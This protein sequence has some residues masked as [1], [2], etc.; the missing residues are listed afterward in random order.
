MCLLVSKEPA[1]SAVTAPGVL[2][3]GT[4][5]RKLMWTELASALDSA[6]LVELGGI[7]AAEGGDVL[8]GLTRL[9]GEAGLRGGLSLGFGLRLFGAGKLCADLCGGGE[10]R[11]LDGEEIVVS[12]DEDVVDA[13]VEVEE[14]MLVEGVGF[15]ALGKLGEWGEGG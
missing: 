1:S 15:L 4:R 13:A 12:G 10:L 5:R 14:R 6:S 11:G 3:D 8:A 7:A 2:S 9:A